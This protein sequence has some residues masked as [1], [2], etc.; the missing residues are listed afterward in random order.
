MDTKKRILV[1][2]D[3]KALSHALNIKLSAEGYEVTIVEDGKEASEILEKE[4]FDLIL[5]DIIMPKMDGFNLL[6]YMKGS[7]N[8][9]TPVMVLSNLGQEED[10]EKA[11]SLGA[12]EYLVKANAP[13]ARIV[14]KVGEILNK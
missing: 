5:L 1:V 6:M 13:F 2:E 10:I 8:T 14:A 9:D 4:K 7:G 11:K 12:T 3:E